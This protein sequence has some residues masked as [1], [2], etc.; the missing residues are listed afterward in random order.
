MPGWAKV[1]HHQLFSK[2]LLYDRLASRLA[3]GYEAL[4][5]WSTNGA[6]PVYLCQ[7]HR[8]TRWQHLPASLAEYERRRANSKRDYF[9]PE[10]NRLGLTVPVM[11]TARL[12]LRRLH[13]RLSVGA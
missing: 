3:R 12:C 9:I 4:A 1:N 8:S 10:L 6:K 2:M 13:Q 5:R 7:H 11:P